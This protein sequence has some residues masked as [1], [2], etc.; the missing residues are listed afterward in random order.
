MKVEGMV[1]FSLFTFH[2]NFL[3]KGQHDD[4]DTINF[5]PPPWASSGGGKVHKIDPKVR[6]SHCEKVP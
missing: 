3:L 5:K 1:H 2:F 4:M 6:V